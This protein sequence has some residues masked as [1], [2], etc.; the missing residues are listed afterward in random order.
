MKKCCVWL[1][2]AVLL[3][4]CGAQQTM[5][6]VADAYVQPVSATVQQVLVT[7]PED[8]AA[9]VMESDAGKLYLCDGYTLT[10]Q[11]LQSGDLDKTLRDTTGFSRDELKLVET[12]QGDAKRYDCVW[13]AAGEAEDQVCRAC[14]LDDGNY[15]YVLTATAGAS[16][17]G[18]LQQTWQELFRSFQLVSAQGSGNTGS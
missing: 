15:H 6:T 12:A 17:A 4:G 11:T 18:Q 2:L 1:V 9:P 7:L 16:E 5:E 13:S 8:A 3:T 10:L 14:V